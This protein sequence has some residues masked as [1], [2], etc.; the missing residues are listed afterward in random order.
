MKIIVDENIPFG[1]EAFSTFGPVTV[2]PGRHIT[3]ESLGDATVLIVRS[4]TP[5]NHDLLKE[6]AIQFVGTAT[7]G[8]DHIDLA[9]LS[10]QKIGFADAAGSNANSV[11]EYVLTALVMVAER[12]NVSLEG[13]SLGIIGVGRI[14]SLVAKKAQALGMRTILN[15]PP[16][17]RETREPCYRPLEEVL[18]ADFVTLHVPL[19]QEGVDKTF[20]LI[21]E[22][23]LAQMAP[24]SVLVNTSRGEVVNNLILLTYLE[25]QK[26]AGA[27]LDVWEGEPSV[28][29]ELAKQ[30]TI[31]TPH[32]AGYSFDGKVS[33]TL[34]IYKAACN[35]FGVTPVWE[36]PNHESRPSDL[37]PAIDAKGQNLQSLVLELVSCLYELQG[38][39]ARF[40]SLLALPFPDRPSGFD[41]LRKHYPIRREFFASSVG[42]QHASPTIISQLNALG[43]SVYPV[44][45]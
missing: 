16:L 28:N 22:K 39:D 2:M 33:G 36:P 9:Y 21:G 26:L 27:V 44:E 11:A 17:A 1:K 38:D 6:S 12:L 23:Q 30:V 14:G 32:I 19:I 45:K 31:A 3:S 4:V 5:V 10:E 40:R 37:A 25:D 18:Q 8:V 35:Y 43:F 20:Y 7:A 29:W 34:M 15:D 24:S 13:K 42:L 41:N